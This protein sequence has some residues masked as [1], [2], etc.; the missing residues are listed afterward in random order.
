MESC[1]SPI[2]FYLFVRRGMC[3]NKCRVICAAADGG[4]VWGMEGLIAALGEGEE[5]SGWSDVRTSER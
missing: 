4:P 1:S 2:F 3:C 5:M